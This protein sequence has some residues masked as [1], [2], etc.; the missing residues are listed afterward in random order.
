MG[1]FDR[2]KRGISQREMEYEWKADVLKAVISRMNNPQIMDG[3]VYMPSEVE[4]SKKGSLDTATG[5]SGMG[6]G[7]SGIATG[8]SGMATG[9][10]TGTGSASFPAIGGATAP[11][12]PRGPASTIPEEIIPEADGK[13]G[14]WIEKLEIKKFKQ[15]LQSFLE[16][17]TFKD[18]YFEDAPFIAS[19]VATALVNGKHII[20]YGPP[21]TGKTSIA[22]EVCD[23]YGAEYSLVT[24]TSDWSTFDTIGGYILDR[25]GN[26]TFNPGLF[27]RS[28][29]DQG[30][31][32]NKW[33]IID[34]IN[35]ADIDKAF[36]PMFSAL[37]GDDVT[38]AHQIQGKNIHI[39]GKADGDEVLEPNKFF[40]HPDWRILATLNTFDKASLYEMSYAF[41]RR[42][43]FIPIMIPEDLEGAVDGLIKVWG[44]DVDDTTKHNLLLLW[45]HINRFRR[46]GPA[47][48]RD[49]FRS[50]IETNNYNAAIIMY[51]LPQ[52]EGMEEH[53]IKEFLYSLTD[54]L[55]KEISVDILKAAM[56]DFINVDLTSV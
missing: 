28:Y 22:K 9:D 40:V 48:I 10:A 35:R 37:T 50:I 18:L 6:T 15:D 11:Q 53:K 45:K 47:I 26:L 52:F 42:F 24:G 36:G 3:K 12:G 33:L 41:M 43:S 56:E 4:Y 2:R 13:Y 21:G 16:E 44:M 49:L 39:E 34:E 14:E 5:G 7:G 23:V 27:L 1:I 8:G 17:F 46:I 29:K 55:M 38:L 31:P 51:V 25:T 54:L 19:M 20:F 32:A 30:E